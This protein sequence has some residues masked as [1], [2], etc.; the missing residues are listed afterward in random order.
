VGGFPPSPPFAVTMV[1]YLV[2][3]LAYSLMLKRIALAATLTASLLYT[4]RIVNGRRAGG[5]G[6]EPLVSGRL[7]VRGLRAV[8][9]HTAC[10]GRV[11]ESG[12]AEKHHRS[13][14]NQNVRPPLRSGGEAA[15]PEGLHGQAQADVGP[16][17]A[18]NLRRCLLSH[19]R[20]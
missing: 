11:A 7:D 3:K 5:R 10:R 20:F 2:T 6:A 13:E 4:L 9:G 1:S 18:A 16:E 8:A 19:E 14:M 17:A 15:L 12:A